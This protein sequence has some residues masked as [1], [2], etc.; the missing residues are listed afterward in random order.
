MFGFSITFLLRIKIISKKSGQFMIFNFLIFSTVYEKNKTF[1]KEYKKIA[2]F[3]KCYIPFE[4][5]ARSSVYS[6]K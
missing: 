6:A 4:E 2:R 3:Y 1:K 5:W